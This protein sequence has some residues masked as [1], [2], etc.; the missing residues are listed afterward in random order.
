MQIEATANDEKTF[1]PT[2]V[3]DLHK[4]VITCMAFGKAFDK[5]FL[6]TGSSDSSVV[7]YSVDKSRIAFRL[8][9]HESA[10]GSLQVQVRP[11]F[12]I[13]LSLIF[14]FVDLI[15]WCIIRQNEKKYLLRSGCVQVSADHN[16]S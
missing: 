1:I 13:Y 6:V 11:L 9:G 14:V 2:T 3:T 7:I 12:E 4:D 10:V 16:I 8:T 5:D 15:S